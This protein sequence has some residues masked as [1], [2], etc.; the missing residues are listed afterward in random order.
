M[1]V[2]LDISVFLWNLWISIDNRKRNIFD[3]YVFARIEL[4]Y[5][6]HSIKSISNV[7]IV[8]TWCRVQYDQYFPSLSYFAIYFMNLLTSGITEKYEKRDKDLS[9]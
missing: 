5:Y 6:I 4:E 1:L 9:Y 7:S 2:S 8:I 3:F